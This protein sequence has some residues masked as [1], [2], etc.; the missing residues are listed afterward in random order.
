MNKLNV[1][2]GQSPAVQKA[3]ARFHAKLAKLKEEEKNAKL[4]K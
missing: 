1:E 2:Q 4:G 3:M